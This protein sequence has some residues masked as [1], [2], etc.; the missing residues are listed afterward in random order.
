MMKNRP[1]VSRPESPSHRG[2][3]VRSFQTQLEFFRRQAGLSRRAFAD[4]LGI[5]RS[6]YFHLMS[7]AGN[8]S[9]ETVELIAGRIG[10]EPWA[11]FPPIDGDD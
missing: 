2:S 7:A 8:P 4:R 9:L 6:S 11:L 5:P 1:L 10:V 3:L